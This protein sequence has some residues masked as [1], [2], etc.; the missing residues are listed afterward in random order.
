MKHKKKKSSQRASKLITI[1]NSKSPISEAYR[2]LRTNI[3]FASFDQSIKTIMVTSTG[4]EEG[5]STT[6]SNYAIV[7]AQNGKRV[8]LLDADLRK[9]TLHYFFL[10]ANRVGLT[11]ILAGTK[12]YSTTIQNTGVANLDVLTSGPIPPKPA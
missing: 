3:Q 6:I 2:T 1:T 10:L 9:P 4:P 12:D 7:L 11:N 5:K 8:L